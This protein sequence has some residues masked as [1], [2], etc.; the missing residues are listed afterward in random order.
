MQATVQIR[1]VTEHVHR[2]HR[3]RA[4][5]ADMSLHEYLLSE[6]VESAQSRTPAEVVAEVD[7]QLRATR[8]EGFSLR[9]SADLVQV[10]RDGR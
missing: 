7:E 3:R 1:D 8:G 4:A 5:D 2:S 6:L 9:S 10:D